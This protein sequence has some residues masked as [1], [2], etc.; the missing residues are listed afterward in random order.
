M[1]APVCLADYERLAQERLPEATAAYLF[2]GAGDEIT[3][4]ANT[5][6]F[7]EAHLWP[8]IPE[9]AAPVNLET[10][11]FGDVYAAPIMAAPVAYQ[12]L[13][14]PAG[15]IAT[16]QACAA[17]GAG[18]ILSTLSSTDMRDVRRAGEGAPQWFQLYLQPARENTLR[19]L[20]RAERAGFSAI[21]VTIDAALSGVRTREMR[22]GFALP[23][24]VDAVNL[25]GFPAVAGELH[26][27]P[28]WEALAWLRAQTRLPLLVKGVLRADDAVRAIDLGMDGI[29]VSNHGGRILD[30]TP[31]AFSRLGAVVEAVGARAPVLF[32]SGIRRGTDVFKCLSL[33]AAAVLVGRPLAS[34][35]AVNGAQG[36][37]HALRILI[38][39]TAVAKALCA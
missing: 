6:A 30:T 34:A 29:I 39:E 12:K 7:E 3:L 27:V 26:Y 38:E 19:L 31:S 35:L 8:S 33:G 10:R 21:V 17:M 2:G 9:R 23:A 13:F 4:R 22:A 24:H 14:H 20:R 5:R 11:L 18:Y 37:A 36:A 28:S 15:E 32:D 25:R 1:N 16:A